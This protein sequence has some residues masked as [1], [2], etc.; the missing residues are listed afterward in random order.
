MKFSTLAKLD[1]NAIYAVILVTLVALQVLLYWRYLH[2]VNQFIIQAIPIFGVFWQVY[3]KQRQ[4]KPDGNLL[5]KLSGIIIILLVLFRAKYLFFVE[6]SVFSHFSP[7]LILIGYV[8]LVDG[9]RGIKKYRRE[10]LVCILIIFISLLMRILMQFLRAREFEEFSV[11]VISAK[12]TSFMLW[13]LGFEAKSQGTIVYVNGGAIDIYFGCTAIPLLIELFKIVLITVLLFP[14]LCRNFWLLFIMPVI[15][16]VVLS[17]IRLVIIA[18]VVNDEDAFEFWHGI[19]GGNLFTTLAFISLFAIILFTD[20]PQTDNPKPILTQY[21][22]NTPTWLLLSSSVTLLLILF[23]FIIDTSPIAGAN[24]IADYQFPQG[25]N[26]SGW[27]LKNTIIQPLVPVENEEDYTNP[28]S[29]NDFN[30]PLAQ[31]SYFYRKGDDMLTVNLR[32]IVS[33]FGDVKYY[34]NMAF[35]NLPKSANYVESNY[36]DNYYLE[37]ESEGKRY[38]TACL[39]VEGQTTVTASQFVAYFHR[40]YKEPGKIVDWLM[41]KRVLQDR[42]CLWIELSSSQNASL[43]RS[44]M[45]EVWQ[46]LVN[47]WRSH[48]PP[49]RGIS[50]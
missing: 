10:I 45:M 49:L 18:L 21:Q 6:A 20:P 9:L 3:Q 33:T 17:I 14:N 7:W 2:N 46:N 43:T 27:Q 38:V 24:R 13:Y 8:L 44:Q 22:S 12:L 23:N 41:G 32:Y 25:I 5:G 15:I 50:E 19:Q 35:E 29:P 26:I 31:R 11:E 48:F 42:R 47:Y 40:G 39:N 30:L 34:Y 37:F 28:S 1:K 4:L 36:E 16:S